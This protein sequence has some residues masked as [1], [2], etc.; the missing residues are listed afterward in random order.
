MYVLIGTLYPD[1]ARMARPL[2]VTFFTNTWNE[3][4]VL[5]QYNYEG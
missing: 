1:F 5:L 2:I 3:T 4:I